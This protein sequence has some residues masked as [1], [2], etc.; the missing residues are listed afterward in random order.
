[1]EGNGLHFPRE[2]SITIYLINLDLAL[3]DRMSGLFVFLEN[4]NFGFCMAAARLMSLAGWWV[5]WYVRWS[6]N[7]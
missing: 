1:M 5:D 2:N 6:R 7:K 3:F 4:S